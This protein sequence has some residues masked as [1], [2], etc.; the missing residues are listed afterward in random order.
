MWV[1]IWKV[2]DSISV[3]FSGKAFLVN[4]WVLE[5]AD[6]PPTPLDV[7]NRWKTNRLF[8]GIKPVLVGYIKADWLA[9]SSQP[10]GFC[11]DIARKKL[12]K[13]AT[14]GWIV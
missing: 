12:M 3:T 8:R 4:I 9:G 6:T 5:P 1:D 13:A 14:C 2:S 11:I 10:I 7:L